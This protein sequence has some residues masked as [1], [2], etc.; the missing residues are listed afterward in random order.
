MCFPDVLLEYYRDGITPFHHWIC[1]YPLLPSAFAASHWAFV[2]TDL[3]TDLSS[4][5][6]DL[7]SDL[8]SLGGIVS[9]CVSVN[10]GGD[11]CGLGDTSG[12]C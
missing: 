2:F 12:L 7:T 10:G 9:R 6:S 3:I 8:H 4:L 11:R 5:V 1:S